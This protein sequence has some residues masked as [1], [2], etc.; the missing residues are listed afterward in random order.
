MNMA[1]D[2]MNKPITIDKDS[3]VSDVI[4]ELLQNQISRLLVRDNGKTSGIISEKDIALFLFRD[5]TQRNL[6][7]VPLTEIMKEIV[8]VNESTK[9][10]DC[11]N[12]MLDKEISSLAVGSS[13]NLQGIFTKTDLARHYAENYREKKTVGEYMTTVYSWAYA[14]DPL[15]KVISKMI[16]KRIS[17]IVLRDE[18]ENPIGIMSFRDLFRIALNFGNDKDVEDN[19]DPDISIVFSR[20]GFLS[21]SGFG[22]VNT[23]SQIMKNKIITVNYDDD[24]ALACD[25][26]LENKING[27][28]V[29]SNRGVL[30][31]I[32]SKTDVTL[33][34]ATTN[35]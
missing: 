32:A 4:K 23:A 15:Y 28:G 14:K 30:V 12:M 3:K 20:K 16:E 34:I 1:K 25:V 18:N 17:R 26:M 22:G 27:V 8:F 24:L 35:F 31:G 6:N 11:A 21:E 10:K 5:Q 9:I 13:N 19:T 2:L 33:A 7:E 29:L